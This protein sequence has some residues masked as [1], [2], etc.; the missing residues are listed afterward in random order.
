M[1]ITPPRIFLFRFL[2]VPLAG[3]VV[4]TFQRRR[5]RS[6]G[7]CRGLEVLPDDDAYNRT[8]R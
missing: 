8:R 1:A 2:V 4:M 5:D 3:V 7:G 6:R